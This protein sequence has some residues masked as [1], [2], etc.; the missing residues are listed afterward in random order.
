MRLRDTGLRRGFKSG[1][2]GGYRRLEQRL[3]ADVWRVQTVG[4]AVG[5]DA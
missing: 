3:R 5:R 2:D 1:C 4:R